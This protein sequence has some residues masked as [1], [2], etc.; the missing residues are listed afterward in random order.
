MNLK[1]IFIKLKN[2]IDIKT[3]YKSILPNILKLIINLEKKNLDKS[4]S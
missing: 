2:F 1:L 4:S 3:K